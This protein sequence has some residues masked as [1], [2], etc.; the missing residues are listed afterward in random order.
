MAGSRS[1]LFGAITAA[2][3]GCGGGPDI[4]LEGERLDIRA[5]EEPAEDPAAAAP[6]ITLPAQVANADWT[7]RGGSASH[8]ITHP[9]LG[10]GLAQAFAV[11]IGQGNNRR[12]RITAD[13]IVVGGRVFTMDSNSGVTAV[14]AAGAPL[15]SQSLTPASD[16][17]SDATGGGLAATAEVVVAT[18]GFGTVSALDAATGDVFWTQ[19]LDAGAT[20]SPTV[21]G[22]LV[23]VVA[24][25]SRAWAID[26]SSGRVRWTLNG[27]PSVQGFDGGAGAAVTPDI[28]IFP[29]ASGEVL[30][31]FPQGGLRRWSTVVT[32]ERLGSAA[33]TVSDISS[34][35]VIDGSVVYAGNVSGRIAAL[36][37]G[38]GERIW[39]A[40]E[41]AVSPVWPAGGSV[42]AVSDIGELLRL[43][44]SDGTVLWRV[45]LPGFVEDRPPRR[46]TRYAHYGPVLAG[47]RLIVA[48]SDGLI[49]QFDPQTGALLG[50]VDL[51]GGAAANPVVAGGVLY[52]VSQRG[53]LVAFR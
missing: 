19:D 15:W 35:P 25:D 33:A 2:L 42:F 39:T 34:D 45:A 36:S 49:R 30:A 9:A 53:Q 26:L 28:A 11:N 1:I 8:R 17:R 44:A 6:G 43:S 24:R 40:T 46:K 31:A 5:L 23:Y 3:A 48:S 37:L 12:D 29:F 22:D 20:A 7:H 32:G 13:P 16:P 4:I 10:P 18:T 27:T 38:N 51:P 41:G 21:V 50:T 14:S 47:G 52:V